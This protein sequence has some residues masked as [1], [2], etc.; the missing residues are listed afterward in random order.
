MRDFRGHAGKGGALVDDD[1]PIGLDD[2]LHDRLDVER[3]DGARVDHFRLVA[4]LFE[5]LRGVHR[6]VVALAVRHDRHV[7][8]LPRHAGRADRDRVI[9]FLTHLSP[10]AVHELTLKKDHR[11]VVPDGRLEQPLAV[12][13][14][15]GR[16]DLEAGDVGVERLRGVGVGR[17]KL[18][19][20][21]VGA[22]EDDWDIELAARHVAHVGRVVDN[23][24]EGHEREV[25]R[26]ELDDGPEPVHRRPNAEP[27]KSE[28]TNRRVD[29]PVGPEVIE[30]ALAY[31][32]GAIVLGHLFPNE[33]DVVVALHF[34][35]HCFP[36]RR[37]EFQ[38]SHIQVRVSKCKCRMGKA[39]SGGPSVRPQ[40]SDVHGTYAMKG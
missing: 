9:A 27:R 18:S 10:H 7:V 35:G 17:P 12:V 25:E 16:D 39:E 20:R 2:R 30:H 26:H 34:L 5:R 15:G 22:T 6:D 24:I 21:P 11:V 19:G 4:L 32:V 13:G 14:H 36:E 33:E 40:H 1:Q 3:L 38:R 31:L 29:D 23:L 37:A 8:A 28:L